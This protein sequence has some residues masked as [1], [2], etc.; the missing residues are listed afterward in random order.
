MS[1]HKLVALVNHDRAPI[2]NAA[3]AAEADVIW[4]PPAQGIV[5]LVAEE[6]PLALIIDLDDGETDWENIVWALKSN[7]AT[8]RLGILGFT[9]TLSDVIR[10]RADELL[11]DEV[12]E[13][14][15]LATLHERVMIYAR[16]RLESRLHQDLA[17]SIAQP[18]PPLIVK[19]VMEFNA[20]DYYEAHETIEE[21]WMAEQGPIREMYRGVLQVA[22]AY[23]HIQQRNYWGALKMFLR[24]LQWLEPLPKV[25]QGLDIA[26]LRVDAKLARQEL[27][28]LGPARLD[29]FDVSLLKPIR[30]HDGSI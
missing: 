26:Q 14:K 23:Y 25:C 20:G 12:L 13:A 3:R 17:E 21:A 15:Y 28:R 5:K 4:N 18:P 1:I 29:E 7:P 10:A 27:E 8:R 24:S 19:G 6:R 30:S 16:R 22:V 2:E 9:E 11:V